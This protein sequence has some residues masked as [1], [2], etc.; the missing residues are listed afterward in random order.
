MAKH[1]NKNGKDESLASTYFRN[2]ETEKLYKIYTSEFSQLNDE[3]LRFYFNAARKGINFFKAFLFEEIRRRDLRIGGL[4][5]TRKL[6]MLSNNFEVKMPG[7]D[8]A[9][10]DDQLVDFVNDNFSRI[11]IKQF[12]SDIIE[13]Q[14]QGMSVFQIFYTIEAGKYYLNDI[15]LLSNYLIYY[16]QSEDGGDGINFIDFNKVDSFEL[17]VQASSE[18][19]NLPLINI[20]PIYY[21]PVYSFDGNEENGLLNG[22]IDGLIYGY[23]SKIYAVKDWAIFLERFAIPAVI[24]KYDPLMSKADRDALWNAINNFGNLFR[25]MI[26]NTAEVMALSDNSKGTSGS[27]FEQYVDY[28]NNELAIR[29]LGQPSTTETSSVGS[30]ARAKVGKEISEDI[31]R[32]DIALVEEA[33]NGLIKKI[34]DLNFESVSQYPVVVFKKDENIDQKNILAEIILKLKQAG[35]ELDENKVS[36]IFELTIRKSDAAQTPAFAEDRTKKQ[37]EI[38]NLLL[39]LWANAK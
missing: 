4:C 5:Q 31:N 25:A 6:S 30:Y 19:P 8:Q 37:K 3:S 18:R 17:R 27:L 9:A 11:K 15:I 13:A 21:Y 26:P 10:Q 23:F 36:E 32:A 34:I 35:Y 16:N 20:D 39:E 38:E 12:V 1:L 33:L 22:L 24:G 7:L 14:I 29:V 28:W 2:S